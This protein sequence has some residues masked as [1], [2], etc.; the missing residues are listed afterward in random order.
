MQ[1]LLSKYPSG[2]VKADN[3]GQHHRK[4]ASLLLV[5]ALWNQV[6]G[7]KGVFEVEWRVITAG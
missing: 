5:V 2:P 7:K 1:A 4:E 3:A 6:L